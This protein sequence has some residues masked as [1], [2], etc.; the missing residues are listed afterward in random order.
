MFNTIR[1]AINAR[2]PPLDEI[3]QFLENAYSYIS[4]QIAD[5]NSIDEI[6]NVLRDHCTFIDIACLEGIVERFKLKEAETHIYA[7]NELT[8]SFCKETKA[9][10][11]LGESVKVT[12][13]PPLLRCDTAVFIFN[14]D[15]RHCTLE[16]IKDL[17]DDSLEGIVQIHL[18][19]KTNS[20]F[21]T[22]VTCFFPHTLA[23]LLFAK[24]YETLETVKEKGLLKLTISDC[25][26]YDKKEKD[27]V[28]VEWC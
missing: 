5:S 13:N 2:P 10:E 3:K 18:I 6:L 27:E 1:E 20:N 15:P 25:V 9:F 23:T 28:R 19:A 4:S 8:E 7:Y 24:A 14:W 26:I 16:Y 12:K 17:L 22:N 21:S 11:C